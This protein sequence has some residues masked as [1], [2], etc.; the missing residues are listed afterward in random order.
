MAV[1]LHLDM[2]GSS[3]WFLNWNEGA[4]PW[5]TGI[6]NTFCPIHC[7]LVKS[8]TFS[9]GCR[10]TPKSCENV[11]ENF[12]NNFLAVTK[13]L[14]DFSFFPQ[15]KKFPDFQGRKISV[16]TVN[17]LIRSSEVLY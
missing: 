1:L 14:I 11:Y 10:I 15:E 9:K 16:H 3:K 8:F 12:S 5:L 17:Q 7:F 6:E 4:L 13:A 2:H